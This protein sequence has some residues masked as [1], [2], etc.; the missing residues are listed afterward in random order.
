MTK[1]QRTFA[2]ARTRLAFKD[3][4]TQRDKFARALVHMQGSLEQLEETC[5]EASKA[6]RSAINTFNRLAP[7]ITEIGEKG[8]LE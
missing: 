3:L 7:K 8:K 2:E 4:K 1:E 5:E 6:M